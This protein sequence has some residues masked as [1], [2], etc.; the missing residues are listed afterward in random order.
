MDDPKRNDKNLLVF[1]DLVDR[2]I[3]FTAAV[4]SHL[5]GWK[6]RQAPKGT[7]GP[8]LRVVVNQFIAFTQKA[9]PNVPTQEEPGETKPA[10]Q[11]PSPAE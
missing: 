10:S 3:E 11:E 4:E 7:Q 6:Y 1:S 8:V 9:E 2:V 5:A